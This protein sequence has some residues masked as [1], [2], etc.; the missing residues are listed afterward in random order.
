MEFSLVLNN[1]DEG[2]PKTG[3]LKAIMRNNMVRRAPVAYYV[4]QIMSRQKI[5]VIKSRTV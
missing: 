4:S 2:C 3:V 1:N 5:T